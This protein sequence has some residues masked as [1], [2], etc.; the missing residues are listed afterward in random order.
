MQNSL[1]QRV[2][3]S[4]AVLASVISLCLGTSF[5]KHLFPVVGA[6]GTTALRVDI[7]RPLR[8]DS[9]TKRTVAKINN[10]K[11][12]YDWFFKRFEKMRRR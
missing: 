1:G 2:L 7:N 6:Q 3:P 12:D 4:V 8:G 5:A 11:T 9:R 10:M